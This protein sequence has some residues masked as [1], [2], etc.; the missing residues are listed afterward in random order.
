[1]SQEQTKLHFE[2]YKV[3]SGR[4]VC[5]IWEDDLWIDQTKPQDTQEEALQKAQGILSE[6]GRSEGLDKGE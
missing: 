3:L 4:W 5:T 2:F 1:M 6:S